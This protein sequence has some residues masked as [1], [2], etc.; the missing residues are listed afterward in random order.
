VITLCPVFPPIPDRSHDW[1]AFL[2]DREEETRFYGWGR[3]EDEARQE[4]EA[5]VREWEEERAEEQAREQTAEK[6][7]LPPPPFSS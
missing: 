5:A 2:A 6:N 1:L 7:N 4:C 3:T